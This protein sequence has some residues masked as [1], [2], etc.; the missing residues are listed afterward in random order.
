MPKCSTSVISLVLYCT[1]YKCDF[2]TTTKHTHCVLTT[3]DRTSGRYWPDADEVF[4]RGVFSH[5]PGWLLHHVSHHPH[6]L[7]LNSPQWRCRGREWPE[8][9]CDLVDTD[10]VHNMQ[11]ANAS[12]NA[13]TRVKIILWSKNTV[14]LWGREWDQTNYG[15]SKTTYSFFFDVRQ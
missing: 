11:S 4:Q 12:K 1:V 10:A 13:L 6:M 5:Q 14:A 15:F 8:R 7:D 3:W 9:H 2:T